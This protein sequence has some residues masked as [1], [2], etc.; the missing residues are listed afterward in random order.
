MSR[1]TDIVI[2]GGGIVGCAILYELSK[3]DIKATLV[4]QAP[5]LSTGTT[6]ANSG[7][8]HAGFDPKPNT[9]KE[10][11]NA[12]GNKIYHELEKDLG[13]EI[14]WTGSMVVAKTD[15]DLATLH[16]LLER[17]IKNSVPGLKIL[18]PEEVLEKEPNLTKDLKGALFAPSAGVISPFTAAI[19]FAECAVQNGAEVIL[20]CAVTGFEKNNNKIVAVET[21]CGKIEAKYVINA[22]GLAA[23]EISAL[24]GDSSFTISPRKGEYI[25]FDSAATEKLVDSIIFPTPSKLGKGILVC[26]TYHKETFIGP[27]AEN[28]ADKTDTA[29][30]AQGMSQIIERAK[31]L[32]E[33]LPLNEAITEFSGIRAVSDTDDFII[34]KSQTVLGLFHAA[35][36]QSPGLTAAPAIAEIIAN[37]LVQDGLITNKKTTFNQKLPPKVIFK[38]LS[39]NEKNDLITKNSAY[40]HIVCRC[41]TITEGEIVDSIHSI[42]GARTMDGVKRRVRAGLGRCQGG[43]CGPRVAAILARELNVKITDVIK[44]TKQSKLF[45]DKL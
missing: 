5:D 10:K 44:E 27:N 41:E 18:S 23:D 7:I 22:A 8:L 20:N 42:C 19:A 3:Y 39:D 32:V 35:G 14:R 45:F 34:G 36:I 38:N 6:K 16:E 30:S 37:E 11:T 33:N 25:L 26:S 24:A 12:R 21:T 17:G 29:T 4:E 9:W 40:G 15:D 1:K 43:F 2:I 31:S 28:I 13:F